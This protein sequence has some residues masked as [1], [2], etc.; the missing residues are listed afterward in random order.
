MDSIKEQEGEG[1]QIYGFLEVSGRSLLSSL[2]LL[3]AFGCLFRRLE[4]GG[5]LEVS[6][7]GFLL[8]CNVC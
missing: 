3:V 6:G 1:C 4:V 7:E 5:F 2:E 8:P